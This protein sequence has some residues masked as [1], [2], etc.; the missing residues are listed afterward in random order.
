MVDIRQIPK[1]KDLNSLVEF[2]SDQLE[3]PIDSEEFEQDTD[4]F[5]YSAEELGLN[6]KFSAM[7]RAVYQLRKINNLQP[8]TIFW[9]DFDSKRLPVTAMRR[10]LR[11][12]VQKKRGTSQQLAVHNTEDIIFIW[13]MPN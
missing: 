8:Y 9:V 1:I 4:T 11:A 5:S 12:F 7:I 6:E 13:M 2:L 3:W 10:I